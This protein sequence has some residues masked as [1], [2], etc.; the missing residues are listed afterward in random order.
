MS[1]AVICP[2][3]RARLNVADHL[4]GK[5]GTCPSCKAAFTLPHPQGQGAAAPPPAPPPP[6]LPRPQGAGFSAAAL[7]LV[8]ILLHD[9]D[10]E[11]KKKA[12]R[13]LVQTGK[14]AKPQLEALEKLPPAD[15]PLLRAEI[16]HAVQVI[17]FAVQVADPIA[18][19]HEILTRDVRNSREEQVKVNAAKQ[20]ALAA[21]W[22]AMQNSPVAGDCPEAVQVLFDAAG[23]IQ[24]SFDKGTREKACECLVTL[25]KVKKTLK[26][27][28]VVPELVKLIDK[29]GGLPAIDALGALDAE[30]REAIPALEALQSDSH[31][32]VREAATQALKKIEK[33]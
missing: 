23:R 20:A 31:R 3:C 7:H 4:A 9:S 2:A 25:V 16:E 13:A 10:L 5:T 15:D 22:D 28:V 19:Y 12:A 27:A 18:R 17:R 29:P 11:V 21:L 1:F 32:S 24:T 14:A 8:Q 30:A 26:A 6:S 33:P